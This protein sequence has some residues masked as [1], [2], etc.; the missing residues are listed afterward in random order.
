[1]TLDEITGLITAVAV[2]ASLAFMI[3]SRQ[4]KLVY[5]S[6]YMRGLRY[7]SDASCKVLGP[8]TYRSRN[9]GTP[10]TLV[11]MRPRQF[12]LESIQFQDALRA[13]GVIS[14][15]AELLVREPDVAQ[16]SFK[17][18]MDDAL[19]MIR[20]TLRFAV[21][22]SIIDSSTEGRAKMEAALTAAFNRELQSRGVDVQ[23]LEI[24]ELWIQTQNPQASTHAN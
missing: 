15:G 16:S 14:I 22:E 1:M 8:G 7:R 13:I 17:V 23:N 10:I 6:D 5:I 19:S 2:F 4:S 12:V 9:G 20:E 24:T 3:R 18:L 21:V 11:D